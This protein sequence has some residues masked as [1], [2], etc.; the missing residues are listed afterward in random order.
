MTVQ[1]PATRGGKVK[2]FVGDLLVDIGRNELTRV[3]KT[4]TSIAVENA[5]QN[6]KGVKGKDFMKDVGVRIAPKPKKGEK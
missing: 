2:K 3:A 1:K 5:L 6:K 4:A